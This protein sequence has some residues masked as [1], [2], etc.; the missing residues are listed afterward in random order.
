MDHVFEVSRFQVVEVFRNK[1]LR[2]SRYLGFHQFFNFN[3]FFLPL[4]SSRLLS[5]TYLGF[6]VFEVFEESKF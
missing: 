3:W 6:E 1:R 5:S 2:F 4:L